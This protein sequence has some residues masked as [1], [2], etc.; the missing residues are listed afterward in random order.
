MYFTWESILR[1]CIYNKREWKVHFIF[2][3]SDYIQRNIAFNIELPRTYLDYFNLGK[4]RILLFYKRGHIELVYILQNRVE[5][6]IVYFIWQIIFRAIFLLTL[7]CLDYTYIFLESLK[8]KIFLF[9]MRENMVLVYI[10]QNRV[11]Y[12]IVY[13]F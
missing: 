1:W 11:E 4:I 6:G 3:L 9:Y 12:G 13:F 10:L 2:F 8:Y 5:K 7:G